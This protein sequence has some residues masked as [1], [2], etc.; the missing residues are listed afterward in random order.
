MDTAPGHSSLPHSGYCERGCHHPHVH[1]VVPG[2]GISP[3]QTRWIHSGPHFLVPVPVL[4]IVFRAKV[5]DGLKRLFRAGRLVFAGQL[6]G[7]STRKAFFDFLD[8]L[9]AKEWVVYT[10]APFRGPD[11]LLQS[12]PDIL[13][14]SPSPTAGSLPSTASRSPSV[15]KTTPTATRGAR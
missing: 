3:D 2:G 15:E 13:I 11:H 4:K 12:W 10:K 1:C 14:G 6:A 9:C 7:L 8:P 5:R